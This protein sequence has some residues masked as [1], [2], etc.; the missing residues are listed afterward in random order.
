MKSTVETITE[1]LNQPNKGNYYNK[2]ADDTIAALEALANVDAICSD[3]WI[4][5]HNAVADVI[6][7]ARERFPASCI[8]IGILQERITSAFHSLDGEDP[9]ARWLKRIYMSIACD[10][11]GPFVVILDTLEFLL[12]FK[13][14]T[15]TPVEYVE[16]LVC[17][18]ND[19][20]TNLKTCDDFKKWARSLYEFTTTTSCCDIQDINLERL[21]KFFKFID[22]QKNTIIDFSLFGEDSLL[23]ERN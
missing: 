22:E 12:D 10:E 6:R 9:E 23:V 5:Y 1:L 18:L 2:K 7:A 20:S 19:T 8:S 14:W 15:L 16:P 11:P 13:F 21:D 17:S 4:I 3:E